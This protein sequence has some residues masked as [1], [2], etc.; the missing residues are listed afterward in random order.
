MRRREHQ[1]SRATDPGQ[2]KF[3][4]GV[5]DA[6]RAD[7]RG[8]VTVVVQIF[9]ARVAREIF[10]E[11]YSKYQHRHTPGRRPGARRLGGWE[12]SNA[13]KKLDSMALTAHAL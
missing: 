2:N 10:K 6:P 8:G 9:A 7:F 5:R 12:A 4:G 1:G 13:C 11:M 3:S